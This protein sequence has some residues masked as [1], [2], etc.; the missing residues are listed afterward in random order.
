M[1]LALQGQGVVSPGQ[2]FHDRVGGW[3]VEGGGGP[4]A[5]FFSDLNW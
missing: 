2:C 4:G 1:I 5:L 3:R